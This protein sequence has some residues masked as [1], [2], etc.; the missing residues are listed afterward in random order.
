MTCYRSQILGFNQKKTVGD[1]S[2]ILSSDN[3]KNT[4]FEVVKDYINNHMLSMNMVVSMNTLLEMYGGFYKNKPKSRITQ[5]F[6]SKLIFFQPSG[7]ECEVVM[8]ETAS[9]LRSTP[10][11]PKQFIK[12]AAEYLRQNI[13]L[14]QERSTKTGWPSNN[15]RRIIRRRSRFP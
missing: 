2:P 15:C 12:K 11:S 13:L 1:T 5:V 6:P 8:S 10:V 14:Y 9:S 7:K 4:N 3:I